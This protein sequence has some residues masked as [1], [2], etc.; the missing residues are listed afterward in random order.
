MSGKSHLCVWRETGASAV[1]RSCWAPTSSIRAVE[2]PGQRLTRAAR[3]AAG[4]WLKHFWHC[5]VKILPRL[6]TSFI[7]T[8]TANVVNEGARGRPH[9]RWVCVNLCGWIHNGQRAFLYS[10]CTHKPFILL[11]DVLYNADGR[12]IQRE[13]HKSFSCITKSF[14]SKVSWVV[15]W[16]HR[17]GYGQICRM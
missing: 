8:E 6:Q 13:K 2:R 14:K 1:Q 16:M 4:P 12:K 11:C 9:N 5:K 7:F 15:R 10:A 3:W 17:G